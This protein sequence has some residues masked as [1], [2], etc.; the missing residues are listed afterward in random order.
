MNNIINEATPSIKEQLPISVVTR[1]TAIIRYLKLFL[2]N[3]TNY[4]IQ[5]IKKWNIIYN[6][7]LSLG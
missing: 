5:Q 1:K 4:F 6:D 2:G 3:S 7:M